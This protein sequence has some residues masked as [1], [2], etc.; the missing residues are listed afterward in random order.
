VLRQDAYVEEQ[1][2]GFFLLESK[3]KENE[4]GIII[5]IYIDRDIKKKKNSFLVFCL[6]ALAARE[7]EICDEKGGKIQ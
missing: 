4:K 3:D 7:T 1:E 2:Q 5:Y 6:F